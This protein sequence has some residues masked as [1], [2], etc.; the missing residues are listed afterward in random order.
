MDIDRNQEH[1]PCQTKSFAR[2]YSRSFWRLGV[3][4][5]SYLGFWGAMPALAN[6]STSP[7]SPQSS[8]QVTADDVASACGTFPV[9]TYVEQGSAVLK[10]SLCELLAFSPLTFSNLDSFVREIVPASLVSIDAPSPDAMTLPSFWWSRNSIPRRFGSYRLI[11]S[12]TAYEI[13]T[14]ATRVIDVQV[15]A[16]IWRILDY[17]E[18]YGALRHLAEEAKAYQYNLRLFSGSQRDP[19][20]IGLYLCN[21]AASDNAM[22]LDNQPLDAVSGVDCIAIVD[23]DAI[24]RMQA[25]LDAS[26]GEIQPAQAPSPGETSVVEANAQREAILPTGAGVESAGN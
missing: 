21:F 26:E 17:P 5:V 11:D 7:N 23:E 4:A 14:S 22:A 19:S 12:W 16:Q 1:S 6:I 20:L 13:R 24:S 15:N 8:A 9:D 25:K 3:A 18:R 2:G 10:R